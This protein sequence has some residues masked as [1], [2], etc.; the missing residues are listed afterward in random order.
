MRLN[1]KNKPVKIDTKKTGSGVRV[2][3][4]SRGTSKKT[5]KQ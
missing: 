1:K 3:Q 5:P 4:D 2:F